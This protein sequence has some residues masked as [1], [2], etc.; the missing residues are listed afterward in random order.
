MANQSRLAQ[1]LA[2]RY[3]IER[4]VG[5][6]GM[7]TVYLAQDRKHGRP[8][9]IKVLRPDLAAAL[10][11]QRFLRE[12]EI[13]ARLNHPHILPLYDSGEADGSLYYV[14]P[15]V[16][17]ETLRQRLDRERQLPID[18]A[19]RI[20][21]EVAD[22]LNHAHRLGV[23]H[24]DIKPENILLSGGHA[25]IADFGIARAVSVAGN[26]TLTQT[27]FAVGTPAY[28]SPEQA[29][30]Q[31]EL[32]ARSDLYSL[33]CMLYEMLVGEP[34]YTGPTAQAIIARR[35]SAAIPSA[36]ET[37]EAVPE[38]LDVVIR[39]GMA[40][41]AA[42]RFASVSEFSDAL[43]RSTT[44]PHWVARPS[45]PWR[46]MG[47]YLM[48]AIAVLALLQVMTS[49]LALP[50]WVVPGALVLLL[51]G[52][53][54]ILAT[55][56]VERGSLS[57]PRPARG[58]LTWRRAILGGVLAL[59]AWG[60]VVTGYVLANRRS[61]LALE[62]TRL[63]VLP[64]AVRG[65]TAFE[66]LG[67]GIVDLLAR[68]LDGAGDLRT[69]DPG[70]VLSA[71]G[72]MDGRAVN[73]D[74]YRVVARRV[75]AG[76]YLLGTV[77]AVGGRLRIQ[78]S[79]YDATTDQAG[80]ALA[81]VEEEGDAGDALS[82]VDRLAARVLVNRGS[83]PGRLFE[84]GAITSR[85]LSALRT[86][87][88]AEHTLRGGPQ[89]IDSALAGL[90]RAVAEDSTFA[91]AY[92]RLAVAAGWQTRHDMANAATA[93]AVRN[94]SRLAD[95]D[96]RLLQAYQHY[97]NGSPEQAEEGFRN[98][99]R[100]HPDDLESQFQLA[101]LLSN[102]NPMLGRSQAEAREIFDRVLAFDPGFL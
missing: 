52:V 77:Y 92:Y 14:M 20:A 13:A 8:L 82:V 63:A 54:V 59:G 43:L 46:V 101:D 23:I 102:Y 11:A 4:E 15:F 39:R 65:D 72:S 16:E 61:A 22:G 75:G 83:S 33:S 64:F 24:R 73:A 67:E 26:E 3:T 94:S 58:L 49:Q 18:D 6:G 42:D 93:A 60:V 68:N 69:V 25:V 79:L 34:P 70:T 71:L 99:V 1:A 31:E 74:R 21:R 30:G 50:S 44:G 10:G 66:Y 90:Q 97:R 40:R 37:R 85:S 89:G 17:G 80:A 87:L 48:S 27:G 62:T 98:L 55:T 9:A 2:D 81:Q 47:L 5:H 29:L 38:D 86:Y 91:L 28:M 36:R 84:T 88:T 78:A 41:V 76:M 35:M 96:R 100:D 57:V 32:D 7:A 95:R 19:V 51:I 45:G 12:I 56:L 53:P